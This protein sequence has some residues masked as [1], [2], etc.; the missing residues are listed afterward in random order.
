MLVQLV[1]VGQGERVPRP[2]EAPEARVP[3]RVRHH[4]LLDNV[5]PLEQEDGRVLAK[6]A[7]AVRSPLLAKCG[8]RLAVQRVEKPRDPLFDAA[9]RFA[10]RRTR[11]ST[12]IMLD[13]ES[14]FAPNEWQSGIGDVSPV[15][16]AALTRRTR[17]TWQHFCDTIEGGIHMATTPKV[18]S[19]WRGEFVGGANE[20]KY[21]HGLAR[22][23][24]Q[25][26]EA[27]TR[28]KV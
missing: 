5:R 3:D 26:E 8:V 4:A 7:S 23:R 13:T 25:E 10:M 17:A 19:R 14:G 24:A 18:R 11:C 15:P 12:M 6:W 9:N 21:K 2:F 22:Y 16:R 28:K 1:H 20:E 27:R